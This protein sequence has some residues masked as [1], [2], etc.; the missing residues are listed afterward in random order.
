MSL[1]PE[2]QHVGDVTGREHCKC[3]S[4]VVSLQFSA[5]IVL[6]MCSV[7]LI[8]NHVNVPFHRVSTTRISSPSRNLLIIVALRRWRSRESLWWRRWFE[9][10]FVLETKFT[11]ETEKKKMCW[12][13]TEH[14]FR[15]KNQRLL[16]GLVQRQNELLE[17]ERTRSRRQ[18]A[19]IYTSTRLA[20]ACRV[21][22]SHLS[23][24]FVLTQTIW[25][26]LSPALL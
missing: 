20:S 5:N 15:E 3:P 1:V 23:H 12:R 8:S 9:N 17:P 16:A 24:S 21:V 6:R 2:G 7:S 19:T 25:S 26:W 11:G 13:T 14:D 10:H 4:S 22:P 18:G